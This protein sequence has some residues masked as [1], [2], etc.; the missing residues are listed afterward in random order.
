MNGELDGLDAFLGRGGAPGCGERRR[1]RLAVIAFHS[2][3]DRIVKH[4]FRGMARATSLGASYGATAGVA[5]VTK[6]LTGT[7]RRGDAEAGGQPAGA[8]RE[9]A[10][11]GTQQDR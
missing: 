5:V 2:L 8:Q 3:E 1:G 11:R 4:T 10:R 6:V 9:A 7:R